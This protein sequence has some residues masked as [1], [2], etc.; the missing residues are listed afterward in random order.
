MAHLTW[1]D[2]TGVNPTN[3]NKMAQNEDLKPTSS[4]FNGSTGRTLTH[5]YNSTDYMVIINPTADPG[6]TLGEVWYSKSS[7]SVIIYNSGGFRGAFDYCIIP[8]YA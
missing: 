6:A 7:N 8:Y 3:L 1:A 2:D 4:T 5:N